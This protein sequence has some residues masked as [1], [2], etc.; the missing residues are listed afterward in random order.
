MSRR[1]F[2]SWMTGVDWDILRRLQNYPNE[3]LVLT[4]RLLSENTNWEWSTVREHAV[5]LRDNGLLEYYDEDAGI[6]QLSD[7]ARAWLEGDLPTEALEND[8]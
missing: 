4:P 3:E 1:E 8:S 7:R 5:K 6:Y 2:P